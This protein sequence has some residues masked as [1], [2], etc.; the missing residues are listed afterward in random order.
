MPEN[1]QSVNRLK[2]HCD[3]NAQLDYVLGLWKNDNTLLLTANPGANEAR[4]N[5]KHSNDGGLSVRQTLARVKTRY[6]THTGMLTQLTAT[7]RLGLAEDR[8]TLK[9]AAR[10]LMWHFDP[11]P[12]LSRLK[13]DMV[14]SAGRW[15]NRRLRLKCRSN[16]QRKSQLGLNDS[17][18]CLRKRALSK[19]LRLVRGGRLDWI[20]GFDPAREALTLFPYAATLTLIEEGP[21]RGA[22][23]SA[24]T[25]KFI[26][27][28]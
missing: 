13:A 1:S 19:V 12:A 18:L 6:S 21:K 28:S 26:L 9:A 2:S 15:I 14:F 22:A 5:I 20:K 4:I 10:K 3:V 8:R 16:V 7:R 27:S 24:R 11:P 23:H 17:A 25:R